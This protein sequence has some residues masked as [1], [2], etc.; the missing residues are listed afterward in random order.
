MRHV[1]LHRALDELIADYLMHNRAALPSETNLL[2]LM[3]WSFK[4]TKEPT[5]DK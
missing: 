1:E 3:E 2:A 5:P 4:Q